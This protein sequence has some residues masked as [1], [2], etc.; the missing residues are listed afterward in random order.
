MSDA[1]VGGRFGF[2]NIWKSPQDLKTPSSFVIQN[3]VARELGNPWKPVR[4]RGPQQGHGGN[5][6]THVPEFRSSTTL[7]GGRLLMVSADGHQPASLV[8]SWPLPY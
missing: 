6:P 4:P 1:A 2:L 5:F 7:Q 3:Y 8:L